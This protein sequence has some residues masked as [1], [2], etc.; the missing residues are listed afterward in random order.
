MHK[1]IIE[2]LCEGCDQPIE[3]RDISSSVMVAVRMLGWNLG[4]GP[5]HKQCVQLAPKVL[6]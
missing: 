3:E 5:Y 2:V 1:E 4:T 6:P